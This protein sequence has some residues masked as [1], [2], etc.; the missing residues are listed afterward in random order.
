M[1]QLGLGTYMIPAGGPCAEAVEAALRAG[2]RHIDT[3]AVYKNEEDVAIGIAKSGVPRE[4]VFLVTKLRSH[5]H[6]AGAYDAC[7]ASLKR[8]NTEY[9]DLYLVHFPGVAGHDH[10]DAAQREIRKETWKQMER[11]FKE[12][13]CRLIGVSNYMPQHLDEIFAECEVKPCINQFELHPLLQQREMIA[14]SE[15]H[16]LVVES[17]STLARG[18]RELIAHPKIVEIAA[19][20]GQSPVQVCL[21]WAMQHGYVVIPKSTKADRIVENMKSV[22]GADLSPEDMSAI[23]DLDSNFRTCWDPTNIA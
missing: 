19:K 15:K 10:A 3:A 21:R 8:L 12:G 9:V 22:E 18:A 13:K 20:R 16:G 5:D 7:L 2:Y 14:A 6:G 4:Q 11:L 1:P 23:D 17:Y